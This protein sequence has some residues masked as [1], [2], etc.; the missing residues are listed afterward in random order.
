MLT[1]EYRP[2]CPSKVDIYEGGFSCHKNPV[3][4]ARRSTRT[5]VTKDCEL[6]CGCW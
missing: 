1:V 4:E 2:E 3:M 5:K 6:P